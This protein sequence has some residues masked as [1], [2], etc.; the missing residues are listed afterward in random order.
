MKHGYQ[1]KKTN[2]PV[3]P[4]TTGSNIEKPIIVRF[5]TDPIIVGYEGDY[6]LVEMHADG[7]TTIKLPIEKIQNTKVS[8]I[9][10]N[11]GEKCNNERES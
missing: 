3:T 10:I 6:M 7:T 5:K 8:V 4:P 11:G 9:N 2:E 1:P